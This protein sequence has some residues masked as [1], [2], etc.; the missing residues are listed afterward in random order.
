MQEQNVLSIPLFAG[1]SRKERQTIAQ[2]ADELDF[3][4]GRHLVR[5]G[6]FAYEFFVIREGT[7]EVTHDGKHLAD[8]APGDFFGEQ[9]LMG[10]VRRNASVVT[11]SPIKVVVMTPQLFRQTKRELPAV[12]QRITEAV[13]ERGRAIEAAA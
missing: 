9:A 11:T 4:E 8:L 10:G 5:E 2:R 3:E 13:E 1:L 12:C 6:E 7:A